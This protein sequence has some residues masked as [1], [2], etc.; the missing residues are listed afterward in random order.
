MPASYWIKLYHEILRD[1]KMGRLP[2]RAWRRTIEL[3]LLAGEMGSDGILPAVADMAW[4]L[5]IDEA[6]LLEDIA[7][8]AEHGILTETE[9]G[10][11]VTNFASRQGPVSDAERMARYRERLRHA[12]Y[13]GDVAV[14]NRNV[15]SDTDTDTE[16]DAE[17]E[18]EPDA[19]SSFIAESVCAYENAVGL[20]AG[21]TQTEEIQAFLA[22]LHERGHP[23]WW[24]LALDV[25]CDNNA[26]K[27]SYIR[28]VLRNWIDQGRTGL[29]PPS[30]GARASPEPVTM[31]DAAMYLENALRGV[32]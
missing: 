11:L 19:L 23:E 1:P 22:D 18:P 13:N 30:N 2:D 21:A 20:V 9:D 24:Q 5:R 15:E 7:T 26:R 28:A 3:F 16:S 31:T 32:D 27:W 29:R 4:Q 6:T 10:W 12:Q 17:S 14:T 8:L 25:A